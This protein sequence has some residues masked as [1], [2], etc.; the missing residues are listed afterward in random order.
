MP[1]CSF[2]NYKN[3]TS[4]T[5]KK[6]GITYFRF[7]R[8]PVQ[9]A[10]WI[11]IIARQRSEEFFKP[12]QG[13]VVCS[14]HFLETDKYVTKKGVTKKIHHH[15]IRWMRDAQDR[16]LWRRLREAYLQQWTSYG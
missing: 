10:K 4:R 1:Q 12:T 5:L 3:H 15:V 13:R 8:N 9:C 14:K 11:T 16:S 2:K 6:D 7:P